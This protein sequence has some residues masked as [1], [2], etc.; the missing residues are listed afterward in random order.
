MILSRQGAIH[1][2]EVCMTQCSSALVKQEDE[3]VMAHLRL[4]SS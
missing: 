2:D 4:V 3:A 1:A